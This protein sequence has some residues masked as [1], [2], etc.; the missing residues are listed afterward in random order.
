MPFS[1]FNQTTLEPTAFVDVVVEIERAMRKKPFL[2]GYRHKQTGVEYHHASA[3][4]VQKVRAASSVTKYCRDTQTSQQ[5]HLYQQTTNDM[6]TQMTKIGVYVSN[7]TD[8]LLTPGHYTTA[9]EH[10]NMIIEQVR[11]CVWGG[12]GRCPFN[13]IHFISFQVSFQCHSFHFIS[14]ISIEL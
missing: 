1:E 4:T 11:V 10:H 8:K 5:H 6:S 3:Q 9:E 13:V 12:G 14:I 2:G 7:M